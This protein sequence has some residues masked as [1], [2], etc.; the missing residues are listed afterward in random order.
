MPAWPAFGAATV[1]LTGGFVLLAR[2]SA[3]TIQ[4]A[5]D[6]RTDPA[7][8]PH[9]AAPLLG[10]DRLLIGNVLASHGLLL[11]LLVGTVWATQVPATTLGVR[12]VTLES[13]GL[14]GALGLGLA[15]GNEGAASLADRVGLDRDERLRELLAPN[16][17]AG[18][19]GLLLVVLPLVA[20]AEELLF[21][22]LLIGGLGAGFGLPAWVLVALSSVP[23]G[24]GHQLQGNAGVVVTT[25]LG[26]AL[27]GAYV[28]TGS[29]VA[30]VVAHYLVNAVEFLFNERPARGGG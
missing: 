26:L 17:P 12:Y 5:L 7:A 30:V 28:L 15:L 9:P 13:V 8:P 11:A 14:G 24:L 19:L 20:V 22:A 1:V 6:A 29:L 23:F 2:S 4:D 10:S 21:R 3:A 16:G 27:G 25:S 18:W